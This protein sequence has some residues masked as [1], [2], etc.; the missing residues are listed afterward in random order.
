MGA[1]TPSLPSL[2]ASDRGAE[3]APSLRLAAPILNGLVDARGEAPWR[4]VGGISLVTR[5]VRSL[6]L[7]G[8]QQ[9]AVLC[10]AVL[11]AST[12]GARHA[13]TTA[14]TFTLAPG[15][16][17]ADALAR[18]AGS[19]LVLVVNG[20]LLVDRRLL[21]ALIAERAPVVVRPP[22]GELRVGLAILDAHCA[23]RF[24]E[25]LAAAEPLPC[26]D[27]R[28]LP[29]FSAEMRGETAILYRAVCS[30]SSAADA[31]RTLIQATQKHVMDAPARWL[32]PA[33]ENAIVTRLAPTRVTP[34]QVTIVCMLLG[35]LG[36][37]FLW[38]GLFV[39]ALPLM[40]GVGWLDG[41]DG[42]LARLRL[43]YSPLGA[44]ESYFDF[45]YEN[46]WW[47]ALAAYLAHTGH[48]DAFAW[49]MALVGGNLLDE[50]AYTIG[51]ARLGIALD[52]LSPAD[53]A[54]RLIAGRRNIYA[55]ML[56]LATLFA[57][58]HAGL[59]AMG[60]WAVVTGV[61]HT[62]RLVVALRGPART[63]AH[64]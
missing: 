39:L 21:R 58:P 44:G 49:G 48:A 31:T 23:G 45:A 2:P 10:D 16:S 20:A 25:G 36:A 6:E 63:G 59:V 64:A 12:L 61:V 13:G 14:T 54:F 41:V 15:E 43:H 50:L 7:E 34:N 56:L 57:S 42:K 8:V 53:A 18:R 40:Y 32:D 51:H 4:I 22:E 37:Y 3:S 1:S 29:T 17:I 5:L 24:G 52:L 33:V 11:P 47:I 28:R 46:A 60:A 35:F 27:P 30:A 19:G 55:A 38:H 62:L 9:I 26:V